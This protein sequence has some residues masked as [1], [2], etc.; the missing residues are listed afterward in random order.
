MRLRLE[1]RSN[2]ECVRCGATIRRNGLELSGCTLLLGGERG[3][4]GRGGGGYRKGR[5]LSGGAGV[6]HCR[7]EE[8]GGGAWRQG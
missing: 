2:M 1:V 6:G 8:A 4:R 3:G 7:W 5:G